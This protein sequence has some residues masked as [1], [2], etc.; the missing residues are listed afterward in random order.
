M[1]GKQCENPRVAQAE[2]TRTICEPALSCLIAQS[3]HFLHNEPLFRR[4]HGLWSSVTPMREEM[5]QMAPFLVAP[6]GTPVLPSL[7]QGSSLIERE[8]V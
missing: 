3:P 5:S 8:L 6:A 1:A 4:F 7:I 2:R